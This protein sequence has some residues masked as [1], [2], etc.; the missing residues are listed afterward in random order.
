MRFV[1]RYSIWRHVIRVESNQTV[2]RMG[3]RKIIDHGRRRFLSFALQKEART[4]SVRK[5]ISL[6]IDKCP[7]CRNLSQVRRQTIKQKVR[8]FG[9]FWANVNVRSVWRQVV[10]GEDDDDDDKNGNTRTTFVIVIVQMA[11]LRTMRRF[12][13]WHPNAKMVVA[14][15]GARA[16]WQPNTMRRPVRNTCKRPSLDFRSF[17]L[18]CCFTSDWPVLIFDCK[19]VK[20]RETTYWRNDVQNTPTKLVGQA[21]AKPSE[22]VCM[23]R[24]RWLEKWSMWS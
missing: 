10:S 4:S 19:E 18:N 9:W 2:S 24:N 22:R 1:N 23:T 14:H 8:K 13:L 7:K 11:D 21:G 20:K 12:V 3:G 5:V 17:D 6:A 15:D 16:H